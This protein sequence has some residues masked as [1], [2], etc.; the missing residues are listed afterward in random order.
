M[1]HQL[2]EFIWF[3]SG[4]AMI[5]LAVEVSGF[6][7]RT[8]GRVVIEGTLRGPRGPKKNKFHCSLI[9]TELHCTNPN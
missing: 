2:S 4:S 1:C 7:L 6:F 3:D 5:Y 8:G 9:S